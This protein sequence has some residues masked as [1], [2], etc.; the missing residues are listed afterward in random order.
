MTGTYVIDDQNST[1]MLRFM[2]SEL[3]EANCRRPFGC[4]MRVCQASRGPA[5]CDQGNKCY[6]ED[7]SA[8]KQ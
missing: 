2:K 1:V 6:K 7:Q 5:A 8:L 3:H 4:C